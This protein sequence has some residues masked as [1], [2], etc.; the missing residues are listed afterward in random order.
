MW[1]V[2]H[3]YIRRPRADLHV[4]GGPRRRR[5]RL[6]K[7]NDSHSHLTGIRSAHGPPPGESMRIESVSGRPLGIPD[8]PRPENPIVMTIRRPALSLNRVK[9][10]SVNQSQIFSRTALLFASALPLTGS[11]LMPMS[12]PWPV[13]SPSTVVLRNEPRWF[14]YSNTL[15]FRRQSYPLSPRRCPKVAT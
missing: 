11:S 6:H 13:I 4:F 10:S 3:Q 7:S 15:A 9:K 1:A 8:S 5:P 12:K 14:A 2:S